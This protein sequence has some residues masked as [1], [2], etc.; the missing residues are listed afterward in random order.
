[1]VH[2]SQARPDHVRR[3]DL[4]RGGGKVFKTSEGI[5]KGKSTRIEKRAAARDKR[6]QSGET[7]EFIKSQN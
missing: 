5:K 7:F 6:P 3:R 4:L 2:E 1:M